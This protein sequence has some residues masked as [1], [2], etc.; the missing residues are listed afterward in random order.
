MTQSAEKASARNFQPLDVNEKVK[1]TQAVE[2]TKKAKL[3]SQLY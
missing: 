2:K 1:S 3:D